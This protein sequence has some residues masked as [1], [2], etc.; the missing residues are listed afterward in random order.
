M[1][2]ILATNH[3]INLNLYLV[4]TMTLMWSSSVY[5][6]MVTETQ[7]KIKKNQ[8]EGGESEEAADP[9]AVKE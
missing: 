8:P 2:L 3:K 1:K 4:A 7:S 6:T 5:Q 9:T